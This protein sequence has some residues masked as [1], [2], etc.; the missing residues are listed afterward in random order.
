ML[1]LSPDLAPPSSLSGLFARRA[2]GG[3][4]LVLDEP[5][6]LALVPFVGE[7]TLPSMEV[8]AP[9][10]PVEGVV[11]RDPVGTAEVTS[12][13]PTVAA[14]VSPV[15]TPVLAPVVAEVPC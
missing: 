10:D 15:V 9:G 1:Q 13:P 11:M 6:I 8:S 3:P 12:P 2:E 5:P 7:G 14:P 4:S